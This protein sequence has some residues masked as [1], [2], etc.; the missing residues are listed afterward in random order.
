MNLSDENKLNKLINEFKIFFDI[1]EHFIC[2]RKSI[3][4]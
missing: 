4:K 3:F 1:R 2:N